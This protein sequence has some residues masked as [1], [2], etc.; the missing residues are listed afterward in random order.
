[1]RRALLMT[2]FA[3]SFA[4]S[5]AP[6]PAPL[7]HALTSSALG[8]RAQAGIVGEGRGESDGGDAACKQVTAARGSN[9]ALGL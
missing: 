8:R 6:L 9:R 4:F 5:A 3:N 2:D 1:M 7:V